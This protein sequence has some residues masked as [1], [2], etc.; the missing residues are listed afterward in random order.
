MLR[1]VEQVV[2]RRLGLVDENITVEI[3]MDPNPPDNTDGVYG[4][5]SDSGHRVKV[6]AGY[7]I[8]K[9]SFGSHAGTNGII[10]ACNT[11]AHELFHAYQHVY[12][13][14]HDDRRAI[15]YQ[16]DENDYLDPGA[17][18]RH[19]THDQYRDQIF[20]REAWRFG[21]GFSARLRQTYGRKKRI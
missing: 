5:Y 18:D 17:T 10:R 12:I 7:I 13:K 6:Y 9:E 15:M 20:E 2:K 21:K 8:R 1:A 19:V 3:D 4:Y 16:I 11:M 14:K